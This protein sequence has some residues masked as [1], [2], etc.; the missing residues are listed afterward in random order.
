MDYIKELT[1]GHGDH[2]G[3]GDILESLCHYKMKVEK[4]PWDK[5]G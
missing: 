4:S 5:D 2:G 3:W 1:P